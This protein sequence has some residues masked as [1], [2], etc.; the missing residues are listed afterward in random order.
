ME[1]PV[2][3]SRRTQD[4]PL[5][6]FPPILANFGSFTSYRWR[7]FGLLAFWTLCV[8]LECTYL[9]IIKCNKYEMFVLLGGKI[10]FEHCPRAK[11]TKNGTISIYARSLTAIEKKRL[12]GRIKYVFFIEYTLRRDG[13]ASDFFY[14]LNRVL[15]FTNSY[16]ITGR[17]NR[18]CPHSLHRFEVE[19]GK[20]YFRTL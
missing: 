13:K 6:C 16:H 3:R 20:F 10:I 1:C 9:S 14:F 5:P 4:P 19:E 7:L 15:M 12:R 18:F 8:E 11:L 17:G 2:L